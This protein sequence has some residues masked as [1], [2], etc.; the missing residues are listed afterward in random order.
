[1]ASIRKRGNSYQVTVSNGRKVDGSQ[2]IAT[3]TFTPDP[4]KTEKQNKKALE[5]FVFEFEEK[6]LSGKYLNGEKLTYQEYVEI[7]L[8]EYAQKQMEITSLE[9]SE[10]V[11]RKLVVPE[12]GHLKLA[13]IQ[14]LHI[15]RFYD[16]LI[17]NG[18]TMN[19]KHRDYKTNTLRR[20]HHVI[21][22]T[23]NIAVRWQLIDSNPCTRVSPPKVDQEESSVKCFSLEEAQTFLE[24]LDEEYVVHNGGKLKSDG[25]TTGDIFDTRRVPLQMKVF[26][27]LALFGGF[28]LG[29]MIA[30][31]WDDVDFQNNIIRITK[32]TAKTKS[33]QVTKR[34]K[35]HTSIR[36]VTLPVDVMDLL[37]VHRK[38]Q[39]KYRLSIGSYWQGEN[40][41][42]TQSDGR[43]MNIC[44]PNHTFKKIIHRYNGSAADGQQLPDISLHGLRHTSATLLIAQNIDV[45]TVS[46]RL[47]HAKCSTTM[48][49]YAHALK[50]QDEIA[51]ESL[52]N[53][54]SKHG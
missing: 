20:I 21:S 40:Y 10:D 7:W 38:E 51:A 39:Y 52:G 35:T 34:P 5:K 15:Q 11:L 48:N 13:K 26:F 53:L 28:R 43:Q 14:P 29:E 25:S 32:S 49:I 45:R 6:V 37:K 44:T 1:M 47:G 41:L 17:R 50:K 16:A 9:R 30:L 19:G 54:F 12:L 8:E 31:T 18:Y 36:N 46:G 27:Y 3:A 4:Q 23:L 42:F 22:S 33:G 2:I 24:Y